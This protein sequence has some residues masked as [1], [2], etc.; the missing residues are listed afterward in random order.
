MSLVPIAFIALYEA[1]QLDN[2][3]PLALGGGKLVL[4]TYAAPR[5][6]LQGYSGRPMAQADPSP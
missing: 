5:V 3:I 4:P 2:L 1:L 6:R